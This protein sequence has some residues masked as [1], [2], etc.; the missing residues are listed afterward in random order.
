VHWELPLVVQVS[1][2]VQLAIGVHD[3]QL[4][5]VPFTRY[6]PDWQDVHCESAF[7]VHVSDEVQPAIG[8]HAEQVSAIPSTRK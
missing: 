8:V 2:D 3:A 1:A 4:S 5:A 7:V 6:V